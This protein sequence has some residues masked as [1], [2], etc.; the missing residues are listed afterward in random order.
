MAGTPDIDLPP[1]YYLG[2]FHKLLKHVAV[3]YQD[4]F[5]QEELSWIKRFYLLS[6]DAQCLLVRLLS[7]KGQWFRTDKIKYQ[8]LV[9][10]PDNLSELAHFKF[11][12]FE[13]PNS[14][15]EL[16]QRLLS[17]AEILSL[18]PALPKT[19]R[20][21]EL[22]T[23]L[24]SHQA[25]PANISFEAIKLVD[26]GKLELF[27]LLF[28]GNRYQEFAQFVLENLGIH[29]FEQ[30][31]ISKST[32]LFSSRNEIDSAIA[33]HHLYATYEQADKS[34]KS[35]LLDLA[36]RLPVTVGDYAK[37]Q[38]QKLTNL[39]ARDLERLGEYDHS[40]SLFESTTLPPS[41]ERQVRILMAMDSYQPALTL[42]TAMRDNPKDINEQEVANRLHVK[43]A[44]KLGLPAA[45]SKKLQPPVRKRVLDLSNTRVEIAVC[46]DLEH[47][48][49]IPYFLENNFLNTLFGLAFWDIIFA[50]VE[51]AFINPYQRQ[52]LDLYRS[53]FVE[54]RKAAIENR[55]QEVRNLGITPFK[56]LIDAKRGI[57]N[58]FIAWDQVDE[59]WITLAEQTLSNELL[60]DLFSVMLKDLRVFRSG[61]P[62]LVAF[63][64][65]NWLWC[66]V[67]GP[68]DKLQDNQKRWM[69]ELERLGIN[70]EVCLVNQ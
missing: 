7:R 51:G 18:F 24:E 28:F 60:A 37:R 62:D 22:I 32:R 61:M 70:Y 26:E 69:Y 38:S 12:E 19:K 52:P 39:I 27:C 35:S 31:E 64:N 45:G 20:K 5:I 67:K 44:R 15:A 59:S 57:L 3:L 48:G 21:P 47:Q 23:L 33:I 36:D 50:P 2:N 42:T 55:L 66:E 17:K 56:R 13:Y 8:E 41:R 58:P 40:L 63:K 16:A 53:S 6:E 29:R 14:C 68:G 25:L 11:I 1:K 46:K 34:S 30:Y 54:N 65:G 10:I 4:L 43:L 49:W 9:S